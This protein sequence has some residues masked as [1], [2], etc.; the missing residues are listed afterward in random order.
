MQSRLNYPIA[1][2][3]T[4]FL[5]LIFLS[6]ALFWANWICKSALADMMPMDNRTVNIVPFGLVPGE[7]QDDP[8]I[9]F[10]SAA[11]AHISEPQSQAALGVAAYLGGKMI[12]SK[13]KLIWYLN[14]K[15]EDSAWMYFDKSSGQIN[16]RWVDA[17][18]MPD[19]TSM[20][21]TVQQY[22]G[23]D[24]VSEVPD[25]KL[26]RFSSVVVDLSEGILYDKELR[27]FFKINL[28]K[29]TVTKGPQLPR[30]DRHKPTDVGILS[31]NPNILDLYWQP[32]AVKK[33]QD[34]E[35]QEPYPFGPL[36]S[37]AGEL[38]PRASVSSSPP[39]IVREEVSLYRPSRCVLVLDE[40]GRID[41][42]DTETLEFAGTAGHLPVPQALFG[43]QEHA[44]PR[45]LLAYRVIPVAFDSGN[46]YT[47]M[48]AAAVSREGT[49]LSL[50]VFD[51]NGLLVKSDETKVKESRYRGAS[52]SSAYYF[53]AP[54]A[55]VATI[56]KYVLENLHPPILSVASYLTADKIEAGAGHRALLLLPNSFIAM[57]ARD[58]GRTVLER[59]LTAFLLMAPSVLLALWLA[60]RVDK[61]GAL[62]GLSR[63]ARRWW[64]LGTIAFGLVGYVT[65]KLTRPK[66]T[67]VTCANCGHPRRP[68]MDKCHRCGSPW[69]VPELTP[70]AW[71]VLDGA[72]RRSATE[73]QRTEQKNN[74]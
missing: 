62:V 19:G 25:K 28:T 15:G 42:L 71:R 67:L 32:P 59:L 27:R 69:H 73:A 13:G 37:E 29:E 38:E 72:G 7:R 18:K 70:P 30:D 52:S 68:D 74:E 39:S 20:P 9:A 56:G 22:V 45:D 51:A 41:L 64:M 40:S 17:R 63:K 23:P 5:V 46:K 10:H 58:A 16:C 26:G 21:I 43:S 35:E 3:V 36:V 6:L 31:K 66:V 8:N 44:R 61:N 50:A 2:L 60:W 24:G 14:H 48:V 49:A 4:G 33:S 53:G 57:K 54:W 34:Q 1:V 47:G 12:E 55:P 11:H 65:Y